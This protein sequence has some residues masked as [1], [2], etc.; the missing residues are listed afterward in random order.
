V[1]LLTND[2]EFANALMH[3]RHEVMKAYKATL[4]KPLAQEDAQQIRKGIRL[5]DGKTEPAEVQYLAG[6]KKGEIGI[7]IHEGK[8]RQIHRM[9]ESLGYAV[10]K[11]ERVAYA[12][13]TTMG[14]KRGEWRFVTKGELRELRSAAGIT[15]TEELSF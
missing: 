11:L 6:P 10:D 2:G 4:D 1:L 7:V 3:P 9:F 12:G 14:L 5:Y 13:I 15:H 8:N